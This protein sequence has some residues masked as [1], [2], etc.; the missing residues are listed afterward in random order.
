MLTRQLS[1][2]GQTVFISPSGRFDHY[3]VSE[4]NKA[5][6]SYPKGDKYY[7]IDLENVDMIDS[8]AIGALLQLL[9]Y[10]NIE[11]QVKLIKANDLVRQSL[12][13]ASLDKLFIVS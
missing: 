2:D 7:V 1:L 12:L 5:Y 9:E 4:F 8:S 6:M 13:I 10:S 3:A 11:K